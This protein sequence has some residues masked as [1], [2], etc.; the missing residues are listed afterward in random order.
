M[1]ANGEWFIQLDDQLKSYDYITIAIIAAPRHN[2]VMPNID[3]LHAER[4]T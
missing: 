4:S 2:F 1:T 3:H